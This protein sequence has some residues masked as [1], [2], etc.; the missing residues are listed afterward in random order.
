MVDLVGVG[1]GGVDLVGVGLVDVGLG[2]VAVFGRIMLLG[3][4]DG[5]IVGL[6]D[7]GCLV[8]CV[9]TIG[10]GLKLLCGLTCV[11]LLVMTRLSVRQV[12]NLLG[13]HGLQCALVWLILTL[14]T[15]LFLASVGMWGIRCLCV[16]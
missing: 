11:W 10:I 9:V 14:L 3:C 8:T 6:V 15:L 1:L 7:G 4:V 2:G 16:G 12:R 5:V 13:A